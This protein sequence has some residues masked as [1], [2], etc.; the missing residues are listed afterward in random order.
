MIET[1]NLPEHAGKGI[2]EKRMETGPG[3][4]LPC[5]GGKELIVLAR[6]PD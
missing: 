2:T 1:E 6:K 3:S 4:Y 5:Q